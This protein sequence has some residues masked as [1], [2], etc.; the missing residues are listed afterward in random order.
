MKF[1]VH[2]MAIYYEIRIAGAVPAGALRGFE[3]LAA[4]QQT[5]TV[6]RGPLPDQAAVNGLLARL[7]SWG[8]QLV[9]L[10]RQKW[11][12]NASHRAGPDS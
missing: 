8:I 3:H 10:R 9:G 2:L 7:E 6:V 11:S 1:G 5:E 4:D 12:A